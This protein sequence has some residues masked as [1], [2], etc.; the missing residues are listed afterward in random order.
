M[1]IGIHK[2]QENYP[3]PIAIADELE[4]LYSAGQSHLTLQGK[5][6]RWSNY[7]VLYTVVVEIRTFKESSHPSH[8]FWHWKWKGIFYLFIVGILFFA[9]SPGNLHTNVSSVFKI[10]DYR[11]FWCFIRTQ[12]EK[13]RYSNVRR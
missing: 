12:V 11:L 13:N 9:Y 3:S 7:I 6:I 1:A 4:S 2:Q 5:I 10:Y 8:P